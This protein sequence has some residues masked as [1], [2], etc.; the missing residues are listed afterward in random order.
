MERE[1]QAGAGTVDVEAL[2]F[3]LFKEHRKLNDLRHWQHKP[4]KMKL[5]VANADLYLG[6]ERPDNWEP[7]GEQSGW[8]VVQTQ[9][10]IMFKAQHKK[11]V[12]LEQEFASVTGETFKPM[13]TPTNETTLDELKEGD[14][15]VQRAHARLEEENEKLRRTLDASGAD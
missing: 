9:F 11:V 1:Q 10:E 14:A 6:D 13:V 15:E 2:E 12:T 3:Q 7:I 5:A 8:D 4:N